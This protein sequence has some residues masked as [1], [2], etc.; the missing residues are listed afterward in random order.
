MRWRSSAPRAV[1]TV[2]VMLALLASVAAA[3]TARPA[4]ADW[5]DWTQLPAPPDG[6][7]VGGAFVGVVQ[8]RLLVA[9]GRRSVAGSRG[10]GDAGLS[11]QIYALEPAAEGYRWREVG[12]LPHP[13]ADGAAVATPAGL[14]ILGGRT[15]EG[16][17]AE[18]WLLS[19]DP[20]A[21]GVTTR[22]MPPLP[23]PA[24]DA[25]AAVIDGTVYVAGGRTDAGTP[26][27]SFLA[28][29]LGEDAA[30]QTL[31]SWPGVARHGGSLV[32]QRA[33]EHFCVFFFGGRSGEVELRDALRYDPRDGAWQP[34]A[35]LPRP[36]YLA[37]GVAIGQSHVM[38][39]AGAGTANHDPDAEPPASDTGRDTLAY[40]SVTD[41]W[42]VTSPVPDG[43]AR[44]V[45]PFAGGY[46]VL[47]D[48]AGPDGASTQTYWATLKDVKRALKTLDFIVLFVYLAAIMVVGFLFTG[49]QHTG[50]DYFLAGRRIPWWAAGLSLMATQV[51]AIGFVAIPAKAFATD[52][53]Y[54]SGVLAW[55]VIV[56]IVAVAFI[57]FFRRL[58]VVSAYEYLELRF[59]VFARV[60]ASITFSLAQLGRIAVV[61]YLPA[62]ALSSVTGLD[63][64]WC[65]IGMGVLATA[66]TA[67]GGMAAVVWTDVMQSVVLLGGAIVC[68]VWVFVKTE[69]GVGDFLRITDQYDKL[70]LADLDWDFTTAALWVVL[71]GNVSTRLAA[72][73][74]DQA[75]VQRYMSTPTQ[76]QA[77]RALW[78]DAGVSIPWAFLVFLM[79]TAL[80]VFYHTHPAALNPGVDTDGIVPLFVAQQLP[81]GVSGLVVA[82]IFAAAM[83]SLDSGMHSVATV[84]VVDI[85]KKV[86]PTMS[87]RAEMRLAQGIVVL[88]GLFSTAAALWLA[89]SDIKSLWDFF[90]ELMGLFVGGLAGLF[91]LGIFF[92]SANGTGAVVGA[93]GSGIT[94]WLTMVH[95][96]VHF[97]LYSTVGI[98]S[99][100]VLGLI[101]SAIF[102]GRRSDPALVFR[103]GRRDAADD[104]PDN[105]QRPPSDPS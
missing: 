39:F 53:L 58:N 72:L 91:F 3:D 45:V 69:T 98:L 13:V 46:V 9:G 87:E 80:F 83:S 43:V 85:F 34:V 2:G 35:D 49:R 32:A 44:G 90:M 71:L 88:L 22:S 54:F 12:K 100:V 75:V 10:G 55:F 92:R 1:V 66:Y 5:L 93:I 76:Q 41:S 56:P 59:N 16:G 67:F 26:L 31:P 102:P 104:P 19:W 36:T 18:A 42:V 47:S 63:I 77:V 23:E 28:L 52:W 97:F 20:A 84:T 14:L 95:T 17:T 74:S 105:P 79:G 73:T 89:S 65:V 86:R 61:L 57:P 4:A 68:I 94:V 30:W 29:R 27:A 51:S 38:L 96:D 99:C 11:D 103:F 40:H 37:P 24:A 78:L 21:D 7:R 50:D 62:L 81:V 70:R 60:F 33:G 25:S 8:D 15:A 82:A 6:A 101:A 64:V 48:A